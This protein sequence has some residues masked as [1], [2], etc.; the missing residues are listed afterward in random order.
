MYTNVKVTN[1]CSDGTLYCQVP[2][3][4]LNKLSD[5]LRKIED[6]FHCK[7]TNV[8]SSRALDV[9]F[10]DSGTVTSV[11][12]SELREIPPRFLQEMIA[13]PPQ[14]IKCCLADLPQSIGMWTPDAV[15]WLRDSVLNCSDCSIKVTKV[16]ETRGIAH[17]YLFTPKNFPDPHR[18]INRQITN[19]DLWKHQ[20]DVFLSAISSGA[21][22]PNS[23][24]GNMPM[25]GNTGE[26]FRK[27]LTDVI[28]K[29]MVD[30]TSAF[31]TEELPPPVHL[32][33]PGEHMDVY[34]PVACHP[35]YFVIQPWQEIH[36]LEVLMEEMILYYSVSEE[37]HIAV[38]KDQVYAAKVE[39]KWHRV[40]L[41]GI[42]TNGL[43]SVYELDYGKHELVNIR[44]VQ[45]LVDMFRKLPFQAVTA[46]L[47]GVKCNQWS[48][49][50]SMVFRNHVEKKPLVALVQTVIEN[51]NP[52]DRKVVVYLVDTSLPDTD[53]WIH[54]FMS[55]YL[56]ELSKVN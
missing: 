11:K 9:Q 17:V 54:D 55:E 16:D 43:V 28:K 3:K 38:E 24:N 6:Y 31:S 40:L 13:I 49:E 32:S 35:G 37:R 21:D 26:N 33:K 7:I 27:N 2:C 53:T 29:S 20:K 45:P 46:Q 5:L 30:H 23:K 47:A 18:S 14:A 50:A 12:V 15:L 19:A 56:I 44:K 41:K 42:L 52:W 36:K 22:S 51:A 4:G 8:H 39:N 25:S 34:V 1:I 48:E 10:L